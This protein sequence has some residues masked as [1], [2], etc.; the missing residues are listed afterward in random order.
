MQNL[1]ASHDTDRLPN[2]LMNPDRG[3]DRQARPDQGENHYLINRPDERIRR[4]Q[5]LLVALQ[6]TYV[7]APM[8]YYGDEAGMWG[9]DDPGCR[10]PSKMTLKSGA[11]GATGSSTGPVLQD[12]A[13]NQ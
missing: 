3:Y 6:M 11:G 10:T 5:R 13:R 7:G 9:E 2:I 8:I 12:I 1:I 4:L